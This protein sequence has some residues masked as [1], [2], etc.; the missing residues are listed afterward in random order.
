M[1]NKKFIAFMN[2][3]T[4]G[5]SG[6]DACF[7]EIAKRLNNYNKIIVTSF[8]GKKLCETKGVTAT[9]LITTREQQFNNVIFT[10]IKR[11]LKALF[12]KID[13]SK[14]DIL[15]ST[16]DFLPD[17][18]PAFVRKIS[19]KEVKWVQKVF[20]LIPSNRIIPYYA[21]KISFFFVKHFADLIIVDNKN[22]KRELISKGF[23]ERKV[24]VNYLGINL[25]YFQKLPQF[26]KKVYDGV[27]LG[28][29]HPSKGIFDLIKIWKIVVKYNPK[30]K[31]AI[32]G[33]GDVKIIE[34]FKNEIQKKRLQD[35]IILLGFLED[36]EAFS[37]LKKSKIFVFPSHEEGF[38][39]A[40]AEAMACGLPVVAWDL[41]VFK[42][43]FPKGM[44]RVPISNVE[45]FA[46]AILKLIENE[47]LYRKLTTEIEEIIRHFDWDAVAERELSLIES[48]F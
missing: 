14:G 44:L 34:K 25:K 35:N 7:I 20:H 45:K 21:Q 15:Y 38:G 10:Y 31:L 43:I 17:V 11:I 4:Q 19:K 30:L 26:S 32:I 16:S 9:Y 40:V 27:F 2:A 13:I 28:R 29:L 37:V 18:I 41:P 12:L 48:L 23:P 39:L 3:Y 46:E 8:L 42:E 5:I 6:G 24:V 33:S 22:L 1:N 47:N 36:D